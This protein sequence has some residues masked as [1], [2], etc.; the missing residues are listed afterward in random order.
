MFGVR[1]VLEKC[2]SL[3]REFCQLLIGH[4]QLW[5]EPGHPGPEL[6]KRV[7]MKW[8]RCDRFQSQRI[9]PGT[10]VFHSIVQMGTGGQASR[11]HI[12]DDLPL[13]HFLCGANTVGES[14]KVEIVRIDS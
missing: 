13:N 3:R 6:S 10:A 8:I 11:A 7:A 4:G 14:R 2:P 1:S 12:S 9:Q 5:S